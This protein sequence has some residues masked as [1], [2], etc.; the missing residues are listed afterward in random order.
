MSQ[1]NCTQRSWR[2]RVASECKSRLIVTACWH[3]WSASM[4]MSTLRVFC[5]PWYMSL[6]ALANSCTANHQKANVNKTLQY[7]GRW[8]SR[9]LYAVH[10]GLLA[11]GTLVTLP[12]NSNLLCTFDAAGH[13]MPMA[14]AAAGGST[15]LNA[16]CLALL[17]G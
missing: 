12:T 6:P 2:M 4:H 16:S 9:Q 11:V 17:H 1:T 10:G 15:Y 3:G 7:V 5:G 14:A 13:V 8:R